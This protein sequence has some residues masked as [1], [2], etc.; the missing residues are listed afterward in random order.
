MAREVAPREPA[1]ERVDARDGD[2]DQNARPQPPRRRRRE[3]RRGVQASEKS[4][5]FFEHGGQQRRAGE[6]RRHERRSAEERRRARALRADRARGG[7][8]RRGLR[9]RRIPGRR[10]RLGRRLGRRRLARGRVRRVV[11]RRREHEAPPAGHG[12]GRDAASAPDDDEGV[13]TH[14]RGRGGLGRVGG[15]DA[16]PRVRGGNRQGSR[17]RP[18]EG[19]HRVR[20]GDVLERGDAGANRGVLRARRV[21][22]RSPE[23]PPGRVQ[24]AAVPR[25]R[26]GRR[27]APEQGARGHGAPT[28]RGP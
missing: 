3:H 8:R 7:G 25:V 12:G 17:E 20:R 16:P 22:G 2:G 15:E 18:G 11:L 10:R 5:W 13:R 28:E 26:E 9:R 14:A 6:E 1:A 4:S 27:A 23:P 24:I 21:R 19:R